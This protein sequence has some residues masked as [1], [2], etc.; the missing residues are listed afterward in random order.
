MVSLA[1]PIVLTY[2]GFMSMQLVDLAFVGRISAVAIGAVGLGGAIF[3]AFMIFGIG[4]MTGLDTLVSQ[5]FGAGRREDARASFAQGAIASFLVGVPL[6]ALLLVLA[7]QL[8]RFGVTPEIVPDTRRYL[9]V[10]SFSLIPVILFTAIKSYFQALQS[11]KPALLVLV[12]ANLLNAFVNWL[13]VP[14]NLG[15]PALG[16]E[17]S[18]WA[19]LFARLWMCAALGTYL[20]SRERPLIRWDAAKMKALLSLGL[21]VALQMTFEVGVFALATALAAGLSPVDLAAHQVVLN[22]AG[23]MFMV[24]LGVGSATAVLVGHAV[25]AGDRRS[26]RKQGWHGLRLGMGFMALSCLNLLLFGRAILGIYT[27]EAPVVDVA[28]RILLVAALFQLS[29]GAQSV[30]TGA[31]RGLG[32]TRTPMS[33]NLIGHWLIGL[34]VGAFLCYRA[35]MGIFG[36]WLGLS[37]GLTVVAAALLWAW[38]RKSAV[39]D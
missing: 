36:L 39:S 12:A 6:T 8:G 17:G 23:F 20:Y 31:L 10:L 28:V 21:P 30:A 26:A 22:I 27:H 16:A 29:D 13:L 7:S 33:A 4:L 11:P 35:E 24:P 37:L 15:A 32:D 14:G 5:A 34:P 25:G 18:A 2:L 3:S 38:A 1:L 9:T 19:T